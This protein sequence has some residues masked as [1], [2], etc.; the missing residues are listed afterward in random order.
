MTI[1]LNHREIFQDV[2][3]GVFHGS[4][5]KHITGRR[6][7][8]KACWLELNCSDIEGPHPNCVIDERGSDIKADCLL[9]DDINNKEDCE[10]WRINDYE[11]KE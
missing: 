11:Y 9:A 2:S 8:E 6:N 10:Y 3:L 4:L 1:G 7:M 5:I